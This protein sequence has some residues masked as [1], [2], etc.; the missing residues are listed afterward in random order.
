MMTSSTCSTTNSQNM[1][2]VCHAKHTHSIWSAKKVQV[3]R[4]N[5]QFLV[6]LL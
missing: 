4:L 6:V 1:F 3:F 5:L 2:D